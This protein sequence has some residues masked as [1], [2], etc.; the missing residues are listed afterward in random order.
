MVVDEVRGKL[1]WNTAYRGIV[2]CTC[3]CRHSPR[4]SLVPP[5]AHRVTKRSQVISPWSWN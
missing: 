4:E 3:L 1:D 2:F 5:A